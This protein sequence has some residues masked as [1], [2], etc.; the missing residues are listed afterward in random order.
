MNAGDQADVTIVVNLCLTIVDEALKNLSCSII[1]P[2]FLLDLSQS[3]RKILDL[4]CL[5]LDLL[6]LCSLIKS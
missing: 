2:L 1:I 6:I 3:V 5:L 4:L